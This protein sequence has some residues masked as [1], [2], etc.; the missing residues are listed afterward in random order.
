MSHYVFAV[1]RNAIATVVL[2]PVAYFL[3]M[4]V[5]NLLLIVV[6]FFAL[7]PY[8]VILCVYTNVFLLVCSGSSD[9]R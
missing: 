1:Y 6:E 9:L 8:I 2:A 3:E 7:V 4:Y 5:C